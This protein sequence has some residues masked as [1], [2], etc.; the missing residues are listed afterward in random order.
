[1]SVHVCVCVCVCTYVCVCERERERDCPMFIPTGS[2]TKSDSK[3]SSHSASSTK[4]HSDSTAPM[5]YGLPPP[6]IAEQLI[7]LSGDRKLLIHSHL[8]EFSG[9]LSVLASL[10]QAIQW[11]LS[12][13]VSYP[14]CIDICTCM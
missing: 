1:M 10:P 5:Y 6:L 7:S 4:S 8:L 11:T 3:T 2:S 13:L 14:L 12:E 9:S